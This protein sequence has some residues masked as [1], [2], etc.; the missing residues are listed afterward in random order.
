MQK[1]ESFFAELAECPMTGWLPAP[2]EYSTLCAVDGRAYL[3]GGQNFDTNKEVA[4]V[5]LRGGYNLADSLT[6]WKNEQFTLHNFDIDRL[7][8]RCR[9]TTCVY[10][11][12][13]LIFGGCFMYNRK[14]QVRES[15]NQL[16]VFDPKLKTMTLISPKGIT[17]QERKDH[18]AA[19]YGKYLIR[20]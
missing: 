8:G 20:D 17:P 15:T 2:R 1:R 9:H 13:I 12:Q 10:R 11:N 19:V 5:H 3:I 4:S 14:R 16:F 6:N 7:Q 18:A